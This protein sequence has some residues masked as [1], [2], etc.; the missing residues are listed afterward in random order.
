MTFTFIPDAMGHGKRQ[1]A[2][3]VLPE[4]FKPV[5]NFKATRRV[6]GLQIFAPDRETAIDQR[7]DETVKFIPGNQG[8]LPC[9]IGIESNANRYG[10]AVSHGKPGQHFKLMARPVSVI[11]RP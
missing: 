11:Q 9:I 8:H 5:F 6:R 7:C 4:F 3:Q 10:L 1:P 2:P